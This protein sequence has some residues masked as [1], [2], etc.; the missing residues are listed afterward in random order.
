M[1]G[2]NKKISS[3]QMMVLIVNTIIG[4]GSISLPSDLSKSLGT[5]GWFLLL[6]GGFLTCIVVVITSKLMKMY[7]EKTIVEISRELVGTTLTNILMMIF[8][9]YLLDISTY[10]IRI[11]AEVI[12]M[13]LLLNT[14][15]EVI[16][17]TMLF[18]TAYIARSGIEP[19]ARLTLMAIPFMTIPFFIIGLVLLQDLDFTNLLPLF[20]FGLKDLVMSIPSSFFSFGGFEFILIYIA[21]VKSPRESTKYSVLAIVI[22][23]I[24]YIIL[25]V[26]SI[27]RFGEIGLADQ[28]WPILA[29]SKSVEFPGAFVENVDGIVMATWVLITFTTLAPALFANALIISRIFKLRDHK[30]FV[31]PLI[32]IIFILSLIPDNQVEVQKHLGTI[33]NYLLTFSAIIL[34]ISFY[35]IARFKNRGGAQKDEKGA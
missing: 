21:F 5:G 3:F 8:I 20:R 2:N 14:P 6:T 31:L 32:P 13:F 7:P 4:V 17:I 28:A 30:L 33:T 19:I 26:V 23:T 18:T 25:F 24:V 11:F 22:V 16:I 10:I 12:K 34:P 35:I 15:T 1:I 27:A 9:L 29:L